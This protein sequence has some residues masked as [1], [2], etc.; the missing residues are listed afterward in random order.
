MIY[1]YDKETGKI[2]GTIDGRVHSKAHLKMWIGDRDKTERVIVPWKVEK[3]EKIKR[4]V[5]VKVPVSNEDIVDKKKG[6]Y[7]SYVKFDY[8]WDEP[9]PYKVVKKKKEMMRNIW[10]PDSQQVDLFQD[11]DRRRK[12]I[13]DYRFDLKTKKLVKRTDKVETVSKVIGFDKK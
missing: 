11:F 2:V 9:R 1:F 12:R 4:E 8:S 6:T 13:M 5:N 3:K 10:K 7:K